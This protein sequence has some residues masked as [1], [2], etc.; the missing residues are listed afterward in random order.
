MT[1]QEIE[2]ALQ[3]VLEPETTPFDAPSPSE[4][5]ALESRFSTTLPTDF[6]HFIELMSRYSFPGDIYNVPQAAEA[7]TNGNDTIVTI[8]QSE[9]DLGGWPDYLIP[10]YGIGNGDYFALDAREGDKSAVYFKSHTDGTVARYAESFGAWVNKLREF[11]N[12]ID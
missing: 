11:L 1:K 2:A 6:K 3:A 4:W 7:K 8:Y 12:G 9:K 10:F 5:Q